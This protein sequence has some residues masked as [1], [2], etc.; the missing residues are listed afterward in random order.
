MFFF[1]LIIFLSTTINAAVVSTLADFDILHCSG[2]L[3]L[4]DRTILSADESC[5]IKSANIYCLSLIG[6]TCFSYQRKR[7][8]ALTRPC[9]LVGLFLDHWSMSFLMS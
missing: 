9:P 4:E 2:V 5:R 3:C 6:F 1:F 8:E 7:N